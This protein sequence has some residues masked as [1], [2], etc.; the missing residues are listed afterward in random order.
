MNNNSVFTFIGLPFSQSYIKNIYDWFN[1]VPAAKYK[2]LLDRH[3][4]RNYIPLQQINTLYPNVKT[5][6]IVT[7]PWSRVF[8]IYIF[9]IS[10]QSNPIT[11]DF[12]TFVTKLTT[13]ILP[14]NIM[15]LSQL[16][17]VRYQVNNTYITADYIFREE[18]LIEDFK[19]LQA[20]FD[21]DIP[22]ESPPPTADYQKEYNIESRQIVQ[23]L[24]K[25][26]IEYFGYTF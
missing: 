25:D 2:I 22:I 11:F 1:I 20:Y 23:E 18:N 15:S 19:S 16:S 13:P 8:Q 21:S 17:R 9:L 14:N 7:N 4:L 26:D 5:I 3:A 24:F 12:N 10:R 6:S